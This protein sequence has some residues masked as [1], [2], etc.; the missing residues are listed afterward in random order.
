MKKKSRINKKQKARKN[1]QP[2][3]FLV[4]F[5]IIFIFVGLISNFFSNVSNIG[6][7]E[8]EGLGSSGVL[9]QEQSHQIVK[10]GNFVFWS[11]VEGVILIIIIA[12]IFFM[13]LNKKQVKK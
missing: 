7:G 1:V 10:F 3:I 9:T 13:I 8:F 11:L 6:S 4:I 5:V 12:L 2:L